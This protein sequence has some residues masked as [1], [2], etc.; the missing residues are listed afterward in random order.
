M[1]LELFKLIVSSCLNF[2]SLQFPRNWSISP[3]VLTVWAFRVKTRESRAVANA[4]TGASAGP[5]SCYSQP[6]ALSSHIT[7]ELVG[8][9]DRKCQKW[10]SCLVWQ[11]VLEDTTTFDMIRSPSPHNPLWLWLWG[12]PA[13][14]LW[15]TLWTS[16]CD[17]ELKKTLAHRA[18]GCHLGQRSPSPVRQSDACSL[19]QHLYCNLMRNP[20]SEPP[21][22]SAAR[23]LTFKNSVG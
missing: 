5:A 9:C 2:G 1:V 23:I 20:E 15:A 16:P 22:S 13:A 6:C 14:M 18:W 12:N 8:L 4:P 21:T 7:P 10:E 17:E 3:Q 19:G 11:Q